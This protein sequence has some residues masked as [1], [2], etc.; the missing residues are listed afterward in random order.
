MK[1]RRVYLQLRVFCELIGFSRSFILRQR[2]T[3]QN[4]ERCIVEDHLLVAFPNFSCSD[5]LH[6]RAQNGFQK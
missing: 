1:D 5:I 4:T 2:G 3:G 6:C